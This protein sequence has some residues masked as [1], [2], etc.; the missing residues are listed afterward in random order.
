METQVTIL[1]LVG[2][3]AGML[4]GMSLGQIAVD[5]WK[6]MRRRIQ[7]PD[8]YRIIKDPEEIFGQPP[9]F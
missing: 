3:L 1:L 9:S 6:S 7:K 2:I 4:L 5:T 8:G